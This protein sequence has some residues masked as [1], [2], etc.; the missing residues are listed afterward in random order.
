MFWQATQRPRCV[1]AVSLSL[2]VRTWVWEV[3]GPTWMLCIMQLTLTS[4]N[5]SESYS[6]LQSPEVHTHTH[7]CTHACT[8]LISKLLFYPPPPTSSIVVST[9]LNSTCSDF[10]YGTALHIAASNLCLGAVKCLLEH[11]ANPTVRVNRL[12]LTK[13]MYADFTI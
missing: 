6:K 5:W 13:F 9:V 8:L 7:T 10:H 11:G 1:S 3:A 12:I 4:P 2:W